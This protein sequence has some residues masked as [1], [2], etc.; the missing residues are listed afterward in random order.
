MYH[1]I[2]IGA[3]YA[4]LAAARALKEAGKNILVLEARDRPGGRIHTQALD[5][6]GTYVDLG[7]QWI[8]PGHTHMYNLCRE[9]GIGTF[10]TYDAGRS[11]LNLDGQIKRYKGIIPPMPIWSLFNLQKG[12]LLLN[13]MAGKIPLQ[14]PWQAKRA[15]EWDSISVE[16]WM[17]RTMR[18]SKA[19]DLFTI[20]FEAIFATHPSTISLLHALFYIGSSGNIDYLMNIRKGAQQDRIVGGADGPARRLAQL[21]HEQ[22]VYNQPVVAVSQQGGA[23]T[24]QTAA[25]SYTAEKLIIALPPAVA[26]GIHYEQPLPAKRMQLMQTQFMGSVAKCYAIYPTPFWRG[27]GYNGLI[28]TTEGPVSVVFDNSPAD[29]SKGILMGFSLAEKAKAL[30]ALPEAERK[31]AVLESFATAFGPEARNCLLYTDKSFSEE[32]FTKGCYAGMMPVGAWT[33]S[34]ETLRT[35]CGLI[36]WAG[37]ET[38]DRW[39]GYME[40]AVLSGLRVEKEVV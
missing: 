35:P 6:L 29:G 7:G 3:G 11:T 15:A 14:A 13:H 5:A 40:G 18:D 20:A 31:N 21:L 9:F 16:Q 17:Q 28:A 27:K 12:I 8:G 19:R 39:N 22:I 25:A 4:G 10:T 30:M 37:T 24:V 34:G 26:A 38:S 2:I 33:T 1:T 23:V 36:H 32:P